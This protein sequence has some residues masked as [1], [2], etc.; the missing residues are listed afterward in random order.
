MSWRNYTSSPSC[1][2]VSTSF[3][4]MQYTCVTCKPICAMWC[5]AHTRSK[6]TLCLDGLHFLFSATNTF[7]GTST[8]GQPNQVFY[9]LFH[10]IANGNV[11]DKV[12]RIATASRWAE[13]CFRPLKDASPL[14]EVQIRKNKRTI[15]LVAGVIVIICGL[16]S[17]TM[18]CSPLFVVG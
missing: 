14:W 8:S 7:T 10:P 18:S 16:I 1:L 15:A 6:L 9:L 2:L 3:F 4:K 12:E 13:Q 17:I 11:G 5:L